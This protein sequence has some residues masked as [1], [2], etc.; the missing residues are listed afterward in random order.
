MKWLVEMFF[1][2]V[3]EEHAKQRYREETNKGS[4]FVVNLG[5]DKPLAYKFW[6]KKAGFR[7]LG[8]EFQDKSDEEIMDRA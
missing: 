3:W 5:W 1:N 7:A 2:K 6:K 4:K 8:P